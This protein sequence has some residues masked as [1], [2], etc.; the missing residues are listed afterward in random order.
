[1]WQ[2]LP[3]V[4]PAAGFAEG[5]QF[6]E[7]PG[8]CLS[9]QLEVVRRRQVSRESEI[10]GRSGFHQY[11]SMIIKLLVRQVDDDQQRHLHS[12]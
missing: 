12:K 4:F 8:L 7:T 6:G 1:M 11:A 9:E 3:E 10:C 5:S 2:S